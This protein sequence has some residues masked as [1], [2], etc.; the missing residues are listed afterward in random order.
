MKTRYICMNRETGRTLTEAEHIRQSASDILHTPVGSRVM[1]REYGSLLFTLIDM[2]QTEA[3][4]LR[5]MSACY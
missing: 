2:P 4:R 1:S 3:L 5:I